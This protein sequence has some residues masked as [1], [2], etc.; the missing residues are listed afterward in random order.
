MIPYMLSAMME[1]YIIHVYYIIFNL[2]FNPFVCSAH[3]VHSIEM[4]SIETEG[5]IDE[6]FFVNVNDCANYR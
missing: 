3:K 4:A 5:T 6:V 2:F 1:Y